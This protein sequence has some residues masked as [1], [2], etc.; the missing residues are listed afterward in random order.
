MY[1]F[2]KWTGSQKPSNAA[3]KT[4]QADEKVPRHR[5]LEDAASFQK[6]YTVL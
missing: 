2:R 5:P 3:G 1:G 6:S 4:W